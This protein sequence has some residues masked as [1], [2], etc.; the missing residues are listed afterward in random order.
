VLSIAN[1]AFNDLKVLFMIRFRVKEAMADKAFKEKRHITLV[2]VAEETGLNRST[3]RKVSS[4]PGYS[5]T[6]EVIDKLCTYFDCEV[7]DLM[8]HIKEDNNSK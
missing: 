4:V 3:L 8:E 1:D 5:C 2:E 7:S 6:T